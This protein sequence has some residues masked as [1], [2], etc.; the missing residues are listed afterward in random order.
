M[1]LNPMESAGCFSII[2]ALQK[3]PNTKLELI[4]F[5][6]NFLLNF[7]SFFNLFISIK[8]IIVDKYF[9]DEFKNFQTNFPHI[10]VKTGCDGI[11]LKPKIKINPVFKLR[12]FI[13]KHHIKLIDFFNKFD[14]DGS[15]SVTRDEFKKGILE[16]G[17]RFTQ[18]EID[19]LI[20]ELDPDGDGEINYR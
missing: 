18:E 3:N 17:V 7:I 19:Q 20:N 11:K 4:D 8:E 14:K 6:V 13:E 1:G 15:M 12:N 5:S 9:K 10:Q 2:K 16:L